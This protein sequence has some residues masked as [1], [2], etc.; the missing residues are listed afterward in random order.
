MFELEA[1]A[2]VRVVALT[3]EIAQTG[4][5]LLAVLAD[6]FGSSSVADASPRPVAVPGVAEP[7]AEGGSMLLWRADRLA[8]LAAR[9][10]TRVVVVVDGVGSAAAAHTVFGQLRNEIW[11]METITWVLGGAVGQR[12]RYLEPPA[13]AF[14]ES[15]IEL[16]PLARNDLFTILVRHQ[17]AFPNDLRDA[18]LEWAEG[19]PMKLLLAARTA[20]EGQL[21]GQDERDMSLGEAAARLMH[22]LEVNGPASASD[23]G[24]LG[25]LGWSRGRAQQV[26]KE[27]EDAGLSRWPH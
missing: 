23:A 2:D 26:F 16:P 18:V 10:E 1:R 8:Q 20:E 19:N 7:T 12:G 22:Y 14:W 24:L 25:N 4:N 3:G 13:D 5:E 9:L 15:V 6:R 27:L 21:P 17:L 11:Q